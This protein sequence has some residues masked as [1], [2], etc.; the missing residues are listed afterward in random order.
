MGKLT[1]AL[2][3]PVLKVMGLMVIIIFSGCTST[4][5]ILHEPAAS[6]EPAMNFQTNQFL[7]PPFQASS[8]LS[9]TDFTKSDCLQSVTDRNTSGNPWRTITAVGSGLSELEAKNDALSTLS[10]ILYS[11]IISSFN[12]KE[13][14]FEIDG[15]MVGTETSIAQD[16]VVSTSLPIL[17]ALFSTEP[18]ITYDS[19]RMATIYL[20]DVVLKASVSLPLY[21]E[22]LKAI[23]SNI[24]SAEILLEKSDNSLAKEDQMSLLLGY[25]TQYEKLA[26]VAHALGSEN[27][28]ILKQS[29]Y[30]IEAQLM[31]LGRV[32]DS[33]EKASRNLT[34]S[35]SPDRVYVYPA[36]LN[37]SG[38]VTEFAEQLSYAI[39]DSLGSRSV[40][41]PLRASYYLIG[42]YTLKDD[43]KSGIYVTY[44][45]EDRSGNVV[46]TSMAELLPV[47]Y[48]GQR[49]VPAA[50][51]FQKQLE[52]GES[53][54]S[55]FS[56]DI[57]INGMKDYLAFKR[58]D[59][60][61]IEVKT[62]SP[63]YFYV[64]GYVFNEQDEQFSYLFPLKV[65]AVGKDM[66]VHRVSPED[67]NK[68]IIINP[69][70]RGNIIPIEVI[71]PYGVEMLQVYAS[72][73]KDYQ[74]FLDSVPGFRESKEYYVVSDNPEEG[75]RL[76]RAL[77]IKE[78]SDQV[79]GE[80]RRGEASISF[81]S[82]K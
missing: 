54:D 72:T 31:E 37:G 26:Y 75:L 69:T 68:W 78:I 2:L 39:R 51:D 29:R 25:Y 21:E 82:G 63:C 9:Q 81:R 42:T 11:H 28:P 17:G 18:Q 40:S 64:V 60:L 53:M 3:V 79:V 30:S 50:Y 7:T 59:D 62:N 67:V 47:A 23:A 12:T 13:Y 27:I 52:R 6:E 46:S 66:F 20:I 15:R 74:K 61:T 43:G 10:G 70:Y 5:D 24:A 41:D 33:Y 35:V 44:R 77:N 76:T 49:F 14:V 57:R 8:M 48:E 22:E 65:D 16:I 1:V 4:M 34:H 36:K 73:V 56:V 19:N 55:E 58:G 45:L 38:G 32:N 71:E 80:I